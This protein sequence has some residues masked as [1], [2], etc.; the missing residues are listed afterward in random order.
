MFGLDGVDAHQRSFMCFSAIC[1]NWQAS[2]ANGAKK[3]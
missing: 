3:I 1:P 2:N